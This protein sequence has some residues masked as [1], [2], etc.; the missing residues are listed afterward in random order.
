MAGR[1]RDRWT[2]S[3]R[4]IR[5]QIDRAAYRT[6]LTYALHPRLDVGVEYNPKA[7]QV[8]PLANLRVLSETKTLPAIILGTSSDRIGTPEGQAFY[9][10]VSKDLRPQVGLP[11][12]PYV[13]LAYGTYEDETRVIAGANIALSRSLSS[14]LIFDGV[15]FHPTLSYFHGR[16]GVSLVFVRS[17]DVGLSY[18]FRF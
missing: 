3:A 14:L 9:A 10:T 6:T 8:A 15:H 12:A 2:F 13:G 16:H 11:I 17:Q 1:R 5:N 7:G 18:S 4:A